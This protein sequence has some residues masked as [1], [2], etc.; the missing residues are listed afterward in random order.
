MIINLTGQIVFLLKTRYLMLPSQE[1]KLT[2]NLNNVL[3]EKNNEA[4]VL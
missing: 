4:T 3:L 1:E 2:Q